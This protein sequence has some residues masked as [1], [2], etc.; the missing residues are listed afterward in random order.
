MVAS[1]PRLSAKYADPKKGLRQIDLFCWCSLN[2]VMIVW[3]FVSS[4]TNRLSDEGVRCTALA[5]LVLATALV[6][7][8]AAPTSLSELP[9]V[10]VAA[11]VFLRATR[12]R[13]GGAADDNNNGPEL[14]V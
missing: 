14:S 12:A 2:T 13:S 3:L 10:L 5:G 8:L 7:G 1:A 6:F 9:R 4:V 11:A